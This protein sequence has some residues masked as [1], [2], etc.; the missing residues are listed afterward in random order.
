MTT[1]QRKR[2]EAL[3]RVRWHPLWAKAFMAYKNYDTYHEWVALECLA[4]KG[5]K[6]P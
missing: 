3:R 2:L 6:S 1:K 4:A 5:K